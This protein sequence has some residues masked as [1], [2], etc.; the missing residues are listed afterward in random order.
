MEG[1]NLKDE[2]DLAIEA[3]GVVKNYG[4]T[5]VLKGLDMNVQ[6]GSMYVSTV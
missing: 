1:A 4:S 2:G 3:R 5:S 6:Y